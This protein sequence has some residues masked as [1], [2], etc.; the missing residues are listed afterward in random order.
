MATLEPLLD[1]VVLEQ[2]QVKSKGG[3]V[4]APAGQKEAHRAK[5]I[6]VGPGMRDLE[7]GK[8]IPVD[9]DPGDIVL[10]NPFLG[11]KTQ[12]DGK[13]LIIQ[14]ESEVLCKELDG[15]FDGS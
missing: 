7:T 1:R 9:L 11:L 6:A 12:V 4:I 10:I 15:E 13:E 14:K 8:K 3:L 2:I 5:V